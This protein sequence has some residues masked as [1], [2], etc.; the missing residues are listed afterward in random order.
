[1]Q[2]NEISTEYT[3]MGAQEK[4]RLCSSKQAGMQKDD[5]T[6]DGLFVWGLMGAGETPQMTDRSN[7]SNLGGSVLV[8]LKLSDFICSLFNTQLVFHY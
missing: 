8:Q 7:L 2:G 6:A 5:A 3:W 4:N 1:M